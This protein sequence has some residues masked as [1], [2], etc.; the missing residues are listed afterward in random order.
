MWRNVSVHT[1]QQS[2]KQGQNKVWGKKY[3][4][5]PLRNVKQVSGIKMNNFCVCLG[6]DMAEKISQR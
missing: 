3:I 2:R 5:I 1:F 4:R 6:K